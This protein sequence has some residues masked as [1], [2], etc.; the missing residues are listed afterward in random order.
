MADARPILRVQDGTS[1]APGESADQEKIVREFGMV[2]AFLDSEIA[3]LRGETPIRDD[4]SRM[5]I[6]ATATSGGP[7]GSE[8]TTPSKWGGLVDTHDHAPHIATATALV[9]LIQMLPRPSD[10]AQ[11]LS[12]KRWFKR[13]VTNGTDLGVDGKIGKMLDDYFQGNCP[14]EDEFRKRAIRDLVEAV[15]VG[16]EGA[17]PIQIFRGIPQSRLDP[18][19]LIRKTIP[20]GSAPR[21]TL[22]TLPRLPRSPVVREHS[23]QSEVMPP[24]PR[25]PV[26]AKAAT[27]SE[28]LPPPVLAEVA[29]VQRISKRINNINFRTFEDVKLLIGVLVSE[30]T[31]EAFP[32]ELILPTLRILQEQIVGKGSPVVTRKD[33][34]ETTLGDYVKKRI[35]GFCTFIERVEDAAKPHELLIVASIAIRGLDDAFAITDS[36]FDFGVDGLVRPLSMQGLALQPTP[37][38]VPRLERRMLIS[39]DTGSPADFTPVSESADLGIEGVSQSGSGL[40]V[41]EMTAKYRAHDLRVEQAIEAISPHAI[42]LPA[43]FQLLNELRAVAA[44][45]EEMQAEDDPGRTATGTRMIVLGFY[46]NIT[47]KIVHALETVVEI[48][49]GQLSDPSSLDDDGLKN[50]EQRIKALRK[51][52]TAGTRTTTSG[53]LVDPSRNFAQTLN[54]GA[55]RLLTD[56]LSPIEA[57]LAGCERVLDDLKTNGGGFSHRDHEPV[58]NETL[59]DILR[60]QGDDGPDPRTVAA[61]HAFEEAARSGEVVPTV[62]REEAE[63]AAPAAE[64]EGPFEDKEVTAARKELSGELPRMPTGEIQAIVVAAAA[65]QRAAAVPPPLPKEAVELDQ[66]PTPQLVEF[67][68]EMGRLNAAIAGAETVENLIDLYRNAN[69]RYDTMRQYSQGVLTRDRDEFFD[70]LNGDLE[71]AFQALMAMARERAIVLMNGYVTRL[72]ILKGMMAQELMQEPA[73]LVRQGIDFRQEATSGMAR[74]TEEGIVRLSELD[75]IYARIESLGEELVSNHKEMRDADMTPAYEAAAVYAEAAGALARESKLQSVRFRVGDDWELVQACAR[76]LSGNPHQPAVMR[77][78]EETYAGL[79]SKIEHAQAGVSYGSNTEIAMLEMRRLGEVASQAHDLF[80]AVAGEEREDAIHGNLQVVNKPPSL[81]PLEQYAARA[82]EL[83]ADARMLYSGA[84]DA[85]LQVSADTAVA[86]ALRKEALSL[87][88]TR[89]RLLDRQVVGAL[90]DDEEAHDEVGQ[91][92]RAGQEM[93][94]MIQHIDDAS[95]PE[96]QQQLKDDYYRGL[97]TQLGEMVER[98]RK[99]GSDSES[100]A[101]RAAIVSRAGEINAELQGANVAEGVREVAAGVYGL[102]SVQDEPVRP[103]VGIGL[104][105]IR[106]SVPAPAEEIDPYAPENILNQGE[107]DALLGAIDME[108]EEELPDVMGGELLAAAAP[109]TAGSVSPERLAPREEVLEALDHEDILTSALSHAQIQRRTSAPPAAVPPERQMDDLHAAHAKAILGAWNGGELRLPPNPSLREQAAAAVPANEQD[110]VDLVKNTDPNDPNAMNNMLYALAARRAARTAAEAAGGTRVEASTAPL[111]SFSSGSTTPMRPMTPPIVSAPPVQRVEAAGVPPPSVPPSSITRTG[112]MASISLPT[113]LGTDPDVKDIIVGPEGLQGLPQT[114]AALFAAATAEVKAGAVVAP[115]GL[116]VPATRALQVRS[117]P[118]RSH[119]ELMSDFA[120]MD[121][122]VQMMPPP[123]RSFLGLNRGGRI[124]LY[125]LAGTVLLTGVAEA[126]QWGFKKVGDFFVGNA[127]AAVATFNSP[128]SGQQDRFKGT[129]PNFQHGPHEEVSPEKVA[130][131][132]P[133]ASIAR[134][135]FVEKFETPQATQTAFQI[136]LNATA[137]ALEEGTL[138]APK[139]NPDATGPFRFMDQAG[140]LVGFDQ[141]LAQ[142]QPEHFEQYEVAKGQGLTQ[143]VNK[144]MADTIRSQFSAEG[145]IIDAQLE[146]RIEKAVQAQF[147]TPEESYR[148]LALQLAQSPNSKLAEK[149]DYK[150]AYLA[151]GGNIHVVAEHTELQVNTAEAAFVEKAASAKVDVEAAEAHAEASQKVQKKSGGL[152]KSIG[153]FLGKMFR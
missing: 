139:M 101:D 107:I 92:H 96:A 110:I 151:L 15:S 145:R 46:G 125:V 12:L 2:G 126:A 51:T 64:H 78:L 105:E 27:A 18:K 112:E 137:A 90:V 98:V 9:R 120:R 38:P 62:L 81:G 43:W 56:D 108:P 143:L 55:L 59:R 33:G 20:N 84:C 37:A 128:I 4:V 16:G 48:V 13:I 83:L 45:V 152:L 74:L 68:N 93:R 29:C 47:A 129:Y 58:T 5:V 70:G 32:P 79:L 116:E 75:P 10:K 146:E 122:G 11:A 6:D 104:E 150:G 19:P 100:A 41:D 21:Q 86:F 22:P 72:E 8:R 124:A 88:G 111:H 127:Q 1:S 26:A 149:L 23:R 130:S 131:H 36:A 77:L 115:A 94:I 50:I 71:T 82:D 49:E 109:A 35:D 102:L 31:H 85:L 141:T 61:V 138:H 40:D 14:N 42:L 63:G 142:N 113:A 52:L 57:R 144:A 80:V 65:M 28:A 118:V 95:G 91:I 121:S 53:P 17:A 135:N 7:F 60:A 117:A 89:L 97:L 67:R 54:S 123:T 103:I 44:E 132:E 106:G 136:K 30:L 25:L 69:R 147:R 34:V 114:P 140:S 134:P 99:L 153:G 87:I 66:D 39:R 119:A 133:P 148:I 3:S 24:L 76:S 73:S